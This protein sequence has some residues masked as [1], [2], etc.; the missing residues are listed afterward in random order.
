MA[1]D[2]DRSIS[3]D[4]LPSQS[5]HSD[6]ERPAAALTKIEQDRLQ[7]IQRNRAMLEACQVCPSATAAQQQ[8]AQQLG[9]VSSP[10]VSERDKGTIQGTVS[11]LSSAGVCISRAN[12]HQHPYL[13]STAQHNSSSAGLLLAQSSC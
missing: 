13:A 5:G 8:A 12:T 2:E 4:E 7:R 9:V 3:M 10:L 6:D 1:T 11:K